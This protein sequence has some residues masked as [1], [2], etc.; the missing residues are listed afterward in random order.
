MSDVPARD[1]LPIPDYDHLPV[2]GLAHRIRSLEAED[3]DSLIS[4]ERAHG[5]RLPVLQVLEIRLRELADG[6]V[7]SGGD[8]AGLSPAAAPAPD[9]GSK[10]GPD[11]QGPAQNPPSHGVPTNPAQPR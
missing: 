11:T 2:T 6:A 8:A 1:A 3:V 4:Y 10:V 5:G 9:G 7:P